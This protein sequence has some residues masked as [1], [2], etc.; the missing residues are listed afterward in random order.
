MLAKRKLKCHCGGDA[1][2]TV[3]ELDEIPGVFRQS[4]RCKAC[5]RMA[6]EVYAGCEADGPVT[7]F[8]IDRFEAM[9]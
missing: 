8:L 5:D 2:L 3:K 6:S 7:L 1:V 9:K 4:I